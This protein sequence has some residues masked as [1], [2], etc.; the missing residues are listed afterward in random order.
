MKLPDKSKIENCILI[1]K[2]LNNKLPSIFDSYFIF[3][4]TIHNYK[5]SFGAKVRVKRSLLLLQ[6][7]MV[8]EPLLVWPQR[9]GIILEAKL[10]IP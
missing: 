1:G 2:Y 7:H 10:K 9:H 5:I 4:S 3:S 6:L 8:M